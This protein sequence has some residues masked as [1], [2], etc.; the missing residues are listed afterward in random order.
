MK[1]ANSPPNPAKAITDGPYV[2]TAE[3]PVTLA[4][5][6][7]D[8]DTLLRDVVVELVFPALLVDA[9]TLLR[10][11]AVELVFPALLV[12]VD[13][14]TVELALVVVMEIWLVVV[15]TALAVEI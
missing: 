8:A 13:K 3:L 7:V 4:G 15:L 9:G 14:V 1:A 10:D 11:M 12:G 5:P 6:L 2:R